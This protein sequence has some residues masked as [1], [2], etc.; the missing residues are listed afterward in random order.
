MEKQPLENIEVDNDA[1]YSDHISREYKGGPL[2]TVQKE[3]A[4]KLWRGG[5]EYDPKFNEK[6][7]RSSSFSIY[8]GTKLMNDNIMN[9]FGIARGGFLKLYDQNDPLG[10]S[11]HSI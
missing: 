10:G 4:V 1:F 6:R 11:P 7:G 2:T 9:D 8:E 5:I 3:N